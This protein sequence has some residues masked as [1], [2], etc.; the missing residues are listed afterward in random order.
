MKKINKT[1]FVWDYKNLMLQ[2]LLLII[3]C[4]FWVRRQLQIH[5]RLRNKLK[6]KSKSDT[7]IILKTMKKE[8]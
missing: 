1:E 2:R 5:P 8:N 7:I 4:V 3:C 6:N